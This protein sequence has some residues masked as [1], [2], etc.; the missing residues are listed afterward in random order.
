MLNI[1]QFAAECNTTVKTIRHYDNIGL[2]KADYISE[3]S[4]YRYYRR[5][6]IAKYNQIVALKQAGFTLKD[7]KEKFFDYS[8]EDNLA[9]IEQKMLLLKKQQEICERIKKEYEKTMAE[10]KRIL[11]TQAE[12]KIVVTSKD[13][14]KQVELCANSKIAVKCAELID[15]SMNAEQLIRIDLADFQ[16]V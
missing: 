10:A 2:L 16:E 12:G 5:T 15:S 13:E 8:Y 14:K 4:G 7:I 6:S 11:V 9:N 3:D 1:S